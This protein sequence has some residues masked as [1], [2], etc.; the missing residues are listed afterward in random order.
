MQSLVESGEPS[1]LPQ[2]FSGSA[3]FALRTSK[4][5]STAISENLPLRRSLAIFLEWNFGLEL[6]VPRGIWRTRR[7]TL[8]V[9]RMCQICRAQLKINLNC[10]CSS[11]NSRIRRSS[12]TTLG[13]TQKSHAQNIQSLSTN[14]NETESKII[15]L[16]YK[17]KV[18]EEELEK[19]RKD[20]QK[21]T[22]ELLQLEKS[23]NLSKSGSYFLEKDELR[24]DVATLTKELSDRGERLRHL[25]ATHKMLLEE[26]CGL[27]RQIAELS[28]NE[29]EWD[30]G[31]QEFKR[32]SVETENLR[33]LVDENEFITSEQ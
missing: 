33:N 19:K 6:A 3:K 13:R 15:S 20:N 2:K 26:N 11:E 9:P 17:V 10:N 5:N 25:T 7:I 24:G 12:K 14:P 22:S 21:L 30:R 1:E 31:I 28:A 16:E 29:E 27:E 4:L 32:V 18:L 23:K 8:K